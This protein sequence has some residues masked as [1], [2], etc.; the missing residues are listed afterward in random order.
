MADFGKCQLSRSRVE[1]GLVCSTR[2]S[3]HDCTKNKGAMFVCSMYSFSK[4]LAPG[5]TTPSSK[6]QSS[7][8]AP[9]IPIHSKP[10][11]IGF[12]KVAATCKF[13]NPQFAECKFG[14]FEMGKA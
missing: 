1:Q 4:A 14:R 2:A 7:S 10:E 13:F 6:K 9:K 12:E 8:V 11:L 5:F 3:Y